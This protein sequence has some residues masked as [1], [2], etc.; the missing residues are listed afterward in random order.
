MFRWLHLSVYMLLSGL[1]FIWGLG[2]AFGGF[3]LGVGHYSLST[4]EVVIGMG[5]LAFMAITTPF[6]FKG[7]EKWGRRF[8]FPPYD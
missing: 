6:I 4:S 1:A 3:A 7:M 2:A 5:I 8:N